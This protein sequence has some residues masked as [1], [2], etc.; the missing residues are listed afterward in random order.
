MTTKDVRRLITFRPKGRAAFL[1]VILGILGGPF[2][3][4]ATNEEQAATPSLQELFQQAQTAS[5]EN[6]HARAETLYRQILKTDPNILPARVN[7]GLACYWQHKNREAV[8]EFQKALRT[9]P[10]A[11]SALLFSGLAYLDLGEYDRA[12]KML[13]AAARVK[14]MDPLLFW[15]LGSL[16]MIHLD[17]NAA[18]VFL[19]RAVALNPNNVRAVW[20]LG[21]AYARLAY[22]KEEK[23][24]VPADYA[25]LVDQTLKWVEEQQPHSALLYVFRGDVLAARN[26]PSEALGEYQQVLKVDPRWPDIHLLMGSLL[27]LLGRPEEALAQLGMQ[28][29][30]FPGD[31]RALVESGAIHCRSGNYAGAVPFL[32]KALARDAN[33]Y[34]AHYRLGQAY[35]NLGKYAMAVP[36]LK[37]ATRLNADKSDPYYLLHR[38]YRALGENEKAAWA[39]AQFNLHKSAIP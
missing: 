16:A 33:N 14:D 21:Q 4:P 18:V 22:R 37:Q 1:L 9:S 2:N 12:E 19:E 39:L 26:L 13:Q 6:E 11:F 29:Q 30:E 10:K 27:G 3:Y 24:E 17:T 8:V 36:Q 31:T 5:R 28:L 35:V 38:A 23:P 7:L 25:S 20:L 15:G 32:E 34:E